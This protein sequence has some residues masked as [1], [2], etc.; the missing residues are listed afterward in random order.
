MNRTVNVLI[1]DDNEMM[2][3]TLKDILVA[4]GFDA[5][6]AHSAIEAME[7]MEHNKY[8]CVI[9]DIRMPDMSGIELFHM[10]RI[11]EPGLP[12]ILMTAYTRD[13]EIEKNLENGLLAVL[14]KPL[15]LEALFSFLHSLLE[16]PTILIIDDDPN[17]TNSLGDILLK[18]GYI[19]HKIEK[20]GIDFEP[21]LSDNQIILLDMVLED[22]TGL[23]VL[24]RIK[25]E[26]SNLPVIILSGYSAKMSEEINDA[27]QMGVHACLE[28]P[29]ALDT[30]FTELKQIQNKNLGAMLKKK[31]KKT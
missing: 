17:F 19:I 6:T 16:K 12:V 15:K 2:A 30:L 18:K 5:E 27:I 29:I 10:L 28:K 24:K 25:R 14:N 26:Y 11:R 8:D 20:P 4:K 7:L 22:L 13:E 23:D 21:Y 31:L 1:V 3:K 9:S